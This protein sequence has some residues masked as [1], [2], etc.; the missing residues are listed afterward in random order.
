MG[1]LKIDEK[2][3]SDFISSALIP[4]YGAGNEGVETGKGGNN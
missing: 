1:S 4:S 2:V 3:F